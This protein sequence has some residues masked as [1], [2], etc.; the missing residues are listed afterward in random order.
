MWFLV[1]GVYGRAVEEH[2]HVHA[3]LPMAELTVE[4]K[5]GEFSLRIVGRI[6]RS[7]VD[8]RVEKHT[9]VHMRT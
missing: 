5:C 9:G 2:V 4:R 6:H 1:V 8:V 7:R 3:S